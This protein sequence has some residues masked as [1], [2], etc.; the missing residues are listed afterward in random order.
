[1]KQHL[2]GL[3]AAP[4]TPMN[5]D[6]SVNLT[7]IEK[8]AVLLSEGRVNGAYVC[9]T[10]GEATSLTISERMEI[11]ERW[12]AVAG[13]DLSVIVNVGHLCLADCKMLAAHAQKIGAYAIAA[14]APC[15]LKPANAEDLALFC[16]EIAAAAPKLPFYY[17][18]IPELT[19]VSLP[20]FDFLKKAAERIPTLTG[21]KFTHEDLMDYGRCLVL[22]GGKYDM[23]FGRDEILL[24]ALA[25][26]ARGA[27]G[28]T[29]NFAAPLY[30]HIMKAH[31]AGDMTTAQKEQTRAME[32]VNVLRNFGVLPGGKAI[33]KMIGLDCGPVRLPL[34]TLT[35]EQS[36]RLHA[37]LEHIGFFTYCLQ[38]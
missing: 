17:Y 14:M 35:N 6:G 4:F 1:M 32:M 36:D 10:T 30:L 27:V 2:T 21:V 25:L 12:L 9:G 33:M 5:A 3:I 38:R 34:R 29:Y 26:G 28:T 37:D 24:S 18:H 8:Q 16:A 13:R 7:A 22:E 23:L 31:R 20:V 19:G 15:F 11:A